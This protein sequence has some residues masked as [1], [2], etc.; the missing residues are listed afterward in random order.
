MSNSDRGVGFKRMFFSGLQPPMI[1]DEDTS[2]RSH[3]LQSFRSFSSNIQHFNFW[4]S[5]HDGHRNTSSSQGE[6]TK[7]STVDVLS[8]IQGRHQTKSGACGIIGG[9]PYWYLIGYRS[10]CLRHRFRSSRD[11]RS[12][13]SQYHISGSMVHHQ[14]KCWWWK[15]LWM[16][17]RQ[18]TLGLVDSFLLFA[19]YENVHYWT[20]WLFIKSKSTYCAADKTSSR[21]ALSEKCATVCRTLEEHL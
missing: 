18:K 3:D 2:F 13:K 8:R 5:G 11:V 19:R 7:H 6:I 14:L 9:H 12:R 21:N 10:G 4:N 17:S 16:T 1:I 20:E 15:F